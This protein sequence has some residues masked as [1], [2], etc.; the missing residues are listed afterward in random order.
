M[1]TSICMCLS[2]PRSVTVLR[3]HPSEPQCSYDPIEGLTL[4]ES[5]NPAER[6][7]QLEEQVGKRSHQCSSYLEA[8]ADPIVLLKAALKFQLQDNGIVESLDLPQVSQIARLVPNDNRLLLLLNM[9]S[10]SLPRA[11]LEI[12]RKSRFQERDWNFRQDW[13]WEVQVQALS[14]GVRPTAHNFATS[15]VHIWIAGA[16]Q[17]FCCRDGVQTSLRAG[18]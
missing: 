16:T 13:E 6:I 17:K 15:R 10:E 8:S 12:Y 9:Q 3:S 2:C 18:R 1:C 4:S 11:R 7:R 5:V 14:Q